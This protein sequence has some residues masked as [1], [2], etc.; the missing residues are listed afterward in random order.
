VNNFGKQSYFFEYGENFTRKIL[1]KGWKTENKLR[2]N[3]KLRTNKK[4]K[5]KK[6]ET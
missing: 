5:L 4:K 6:T 3:C 1:E 2:K